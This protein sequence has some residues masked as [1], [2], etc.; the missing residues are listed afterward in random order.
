[1]LKT[2]FEIFQFIGETELHIEALRQK[3]CREKTFESYDV[4]R[5]I[6]GKDSLKSQQGISHRDIYNFILEF[7]D[8]K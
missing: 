7:S 2:M 8:D 5:T 1:M 6:G 4:F 3:V